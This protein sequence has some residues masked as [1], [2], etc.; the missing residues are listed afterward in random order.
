MSED[1]V[2]NVRTNEIDPLFKRAER[3]V[4]SVLL[5]VCSHPCSPSYSIS[6]Q[7]SVGAVVPPI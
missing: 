6:K 5:A 2:R 3:D 4:D 1:F 7:K